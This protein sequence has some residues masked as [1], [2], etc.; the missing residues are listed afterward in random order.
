MLTGLRAFNTDRQQEGHP[1]VAHFC[2]ALQWKQMIRHVSEKHSVSICTPCVCP[3]VCVSW[4]W[5]IAECSSLLHLF[6][7]ADRQTWFICSKDTVASSSSSIRPGLHQSDS[8]FGLTV[9]VCPLSSS[10]RPLSCWGLQPYLP[11]PQSSPG[12]AAVYL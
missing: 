12:S 10:L 11:G 7:A 4:W 6:S 5:N 9:A 8:T 3:R 2:L 1:P